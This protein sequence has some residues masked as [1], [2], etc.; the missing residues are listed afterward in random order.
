MEESCDDNRL[1]SESSLSIFN[2]KKIDYKLIIPFVI[3]FGII[4]GYFIGMHNSDKVNQEV[5]NQGDTLQVEGNYLKTQDQD[6]KPVIPDKNDTTYY[7]VIDTDACLRD[8]TTADRYTVIPQNSIFK[9]ID[10]TT[11]NGKMWIKGFDNLGNVGWT[12]R[13]NFK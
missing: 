10:S 1:T 9:G 3:I 8:T 6:T 4:L 13:S 11:I 7:T 5:L 2:L 12:K